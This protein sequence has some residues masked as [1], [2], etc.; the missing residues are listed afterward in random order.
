M[1][2]PHHYNCIRYEQ[3]LVSEIST[4]KRNYVTPVLHHNGKK[5]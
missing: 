2:D 1:E 5:I 4:K 3:N